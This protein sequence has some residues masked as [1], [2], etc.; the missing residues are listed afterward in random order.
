ME[1]S[2]FLARCC[3]S[4]GIKCSW[5][6]MR[7]RLGFQLLILRRRGLD[8]KSLII[9]RD[10]AMDERN[11]VLQAGRE[12]R[13]QRFEGTVLVFPAAPS[14]P[15]L[16]TNELSWT[17]PCPVP[18]ANDILPLHS[19]ITEPSDSDL[20]HY[21]ISGIF[22]TRLCVWVYTPYLLCAWCSWRP[23]ERILWKLNYKR[24]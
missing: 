22:R 16:S 2:S 18:F 15:P 11:G 17:P 13:S 14:C 24:L 20:C 3:S 6:M 5:R 21:I 19:F 8:T 9:P 7:Q 4:L 1:L 10:K 23:E 12:G